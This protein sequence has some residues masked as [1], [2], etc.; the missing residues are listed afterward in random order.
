MVWKNRVGVRQAQRAD[1]IIHRISSVFYCI[2]HFLSRRAAVATARFFRISRMDIA[3]FHRVLRL[4]AGHF[5]PLYHSR[6]PPARKT[7]ADP[8][9]SAA[10]EKG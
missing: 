5:A 3:S 4:S 7:A 9:G 8:P 6:M 2:D 1:G 10:G